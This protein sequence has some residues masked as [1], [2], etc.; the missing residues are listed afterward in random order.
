MAYTYCYLIT[1]TLDFP[2]VECP[3][4][5]IPRDWLAPKFYARGLQNEK[6]FI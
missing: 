4:A 2:A 3:F 6:K 1:V 5:P